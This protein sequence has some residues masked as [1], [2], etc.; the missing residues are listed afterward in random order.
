MFRFRHLFLH[1]S[2]VTFR[3]LF[4]HHICIRSISFISLLIFYFDYLF[5]RFCNRCIFWKA[6]FMVQMN[7]TVCFSWFICFCVSINSIWNGIRTVQIGLHGSLDASRC[8]SYNLNI[9]NI[10]HACRLCV[11][12]CTC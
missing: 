9:G 10:C 6:L 7:D 3:H 8:F 2:F 11:L 5:C 12:G 1:I 4:L